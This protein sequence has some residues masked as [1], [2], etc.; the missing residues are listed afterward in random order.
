MDPNDPDS[1]QSHLARQALKEL[2]GYVEIWK[3]HIDGVLDDPDHRDEHLQR[4]LRAAHNVR[5][6]H[7]NATEATAAL[8]GI[9]METVARS[10]FAR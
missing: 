6:L 5:T 10:D 2:A 1:V 8:A 4:A 9:D 7:L 3:R